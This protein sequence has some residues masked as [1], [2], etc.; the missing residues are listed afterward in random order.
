MTT[1]P[2]NFLAP[3]RIAG[4][5]NFLHLISHDEIYRAYA[6]NYAVSAVVFPLMGCVEMHLRDS[7]HREFSQKYAPSGHPNPR[8]YPW[9]DWTEPAHYP[10]ILKAKDDVQK[11]LYDNRSGARL[12]PGP[13]TDDV[14]ASLTFGFWLNIFRSLPNVA[15]PKVM[16]KIFPNHPI[17]NP[18][19]WGDKAVRTSL[20]EQLRMANDFRNRVAHHEPLFKFRYRKSYPKN[21]EQGLKNLRSC[22]K[23]SLEISAWAD[24]SAYKS[25]VESHWYRQF[26]QL[27]TKDCFV[28]WVKVEVPLHI[29][30]IT[31]RC[32]DFARKMD[33][34]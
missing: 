4:Y 6:W 12:H 32:P 1:N 19:K 3:A 11:L 9:Y 5:K 16:P 7:I 23:D 20:N 28:S 25:L 29:E 31:W 17:K 26:L 34:T 18:A 22:M 24:A 15:A 30:A 13:S 2:T 10:L 21:L 14:V 8:S 33:L 27:T